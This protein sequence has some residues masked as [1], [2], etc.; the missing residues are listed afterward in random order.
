MVAAQGHGLT[1]LAPLCRA[2]KHRDF[3]FLLQPH[4]SPHRHWLTR[5]LLPS[6]HPPHGTGLSW[7]LPPCVSQQ[8][9][10]L[11]AI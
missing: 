1:A 3:S 10:P 6:P 2:E 7:D 5:V 11:L 8:R 4:S 9:A